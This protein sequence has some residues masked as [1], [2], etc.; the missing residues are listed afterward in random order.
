MSYRAY[1]RAH[2]EVRIV[3]SNPDH[4]M[5][6]YEF[7]TIERAQQRIDTLNNEHSALGGLPAYR[8]CQPWNIEVRMVTGWSDLGM[9][10]EEPA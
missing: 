10:T 5:H 7:K 2:T 6:C 1:P 3:C 8:G 9:F 4:E